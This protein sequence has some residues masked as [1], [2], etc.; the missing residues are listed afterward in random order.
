MFKLR[1]VLVFLVI[2]LVFLLCLFW[3]FVADEKWTSKRYFSRYKLEFETT[4]KELQLIR[5]GIE[6][7]RNEI[8]EL[9]RRPRPRVYFKRKTKILPKWIERFA[10]PHWSEFKPWRGVFVF[11][12]SYRY[13]YL[14]RCLE[15]IAF[16]SADID[17]SSVCIFA[18]D[19]TPITTDGEVS[20][21]LDVIRNVT[22]CKVVVWKVESEPGRSQEKNYAL[23][24]KRH[25]WFVLESVFNATITGMHILGGF[26]EPLP[27]LS[28]DRLITILIDSAW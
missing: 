5:N 10:A 24:L 22:F 6:S 20:Q 18:L 17:R 25:W 14:R 23:K 11:F 27:F 12:V 7:I 19:K 15:S 16:A 21:T 2:L 26:R 28:I 4:N 8:G 3:N 9:K 13:G 1:L